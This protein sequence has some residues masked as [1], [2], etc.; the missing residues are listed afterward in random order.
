MAEKL[1]FMVFRALFVSEAHI[2]QSYLKK[3]LNNLK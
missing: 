3:N 1:S 2:Q